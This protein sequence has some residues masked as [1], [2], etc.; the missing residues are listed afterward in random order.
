MESKFQ[1]ELA[2]LI[3]KHSKENESNTPDFLLAEFLCKC[4]EAFNKAVNARKVWH[5]GQI[6]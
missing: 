2:E 1:E 3:N 4:L 6:K 5:G